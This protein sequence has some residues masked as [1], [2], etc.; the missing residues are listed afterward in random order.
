MR[1]LITSADI[2]AKERGESADVFPPHGQMR[3]AGVAQVME[4]EVRDARFPACRREAVLGVPDVA[5][6][7]IL[8]NI[9]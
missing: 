4:P 9:A 8:E 5:A 7:P 2:S 3:S 6:V 1:R